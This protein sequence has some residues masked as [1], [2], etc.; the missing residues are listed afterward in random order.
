MTDE[1]EVFQARYT[2]HQEYGQGTVSEDTTT[3][4]APK[5]GPDR[6]AIEAVQGAISSGG[7]RNQR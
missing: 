5:G 2:V 4:S 6:L 7:E 1:V 3:Q